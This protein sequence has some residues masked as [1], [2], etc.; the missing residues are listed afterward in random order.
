LSTAET[1][2]SNYVIPTYGTGGVRG[3]KG[4]VFARGEGAYLY[5]TEGRKYIDFNAGIAVNVIG[6]ADKEL[7]AAATDQL[8]KVAH[9]SNLY[10]TQPYLDLAKKLVDHSPGMGKVFFCNSG[11]EATEAAIKF[12]RVFHNAKGQ[13]ATR[14]RFISFKN[15][16]HGRSLGALSLTYKPAIRLPFSPMLIPKVDHLEFNDLDALKA[17]IGPDVVAVMMEPVQGEGGIRAA[18]REFVQL[19]RELCDEHGV[20]LI[21]DEVQIGL[22]RQGNGR[23]WAYEEYGV[24]P[25]ILTMAK[26]LA[27]GLPIGGILMKKEFFDAVP[28]SV[29]LGTHGSTFAGNP[30]VTRVANVVVDR[31][32]SPGFLEQVKENGTYLIKGLDT[33]YSRL[34]R[35]ILEVRRP[36]G[37]AALYAGIHLPQAC[38]GKIVSHCL[39]KGVIVV[40][41][42]DK[43][44][45]VR[46]CPPLIISKED[47]DRVLVVLQEAIEAEVT[48]VDSISAESPSMK[49]QVNMNLNSLASTSKQEYE[50]KL[51]DFGHTILPEGFSVGVSS[52]EFFPEELPRTQGQKPASMNISLIVPDA[53]TSKYAA[54]FTQNTFPGA[55]VKVGRALLKGQSPL[56]AVVINNKISNVHPKQSGVADAERVCKQVADS[57]KSDSQVFPSSTGVIGWRL[58]VDSMVDA[59]PR[60]VEQLQSKSILPVAKGIMT[61]DTFPKSRSCVIVDENNRVLG[62]VTG[63]AKGAGMIEPHMATMLVYILTDI[64]AEPAVLDRVLRQAVNSDGSFNRI[65]VDS[66][67]STSDT[68]LLVSSAKMPKLSQSI[69]ESALKEAVALVS[70]QLAQDVVRN[71]EGT[72]HVMRI[73]VTGAPSEELAHGTAKAVANSPLVKTAIAGNDPNVGRIIGAIGSF[74]GK[75]FPGWAAL[76]AEKC[77]ISVGEEVVFKNGEF[78]LDSE[79]E[80]KLTSYL[81]AN[82]IRALGYPDHYNTVDININLRGTSVQGFSSTVYGADL[83]HTYIDVNAGYRS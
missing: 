5:D 41:A 35:H 78:T 83:T 70:G 36:L 1:T 3:K 8:G 12:A 2:E 59:I 53:P 26:P 10:H 79:K 80:T 23:L 81:K 16:F 46:L 55:P 37:D 9:V 31:V 6:H 52:F 17:S 51:L 11:T 4:L 71:G 65:S 61:T 42:G 68:I 25:D 28:V 57:L 19:A 18:T 33:L 7:I 38:A 20:A 77:E 47:I 60:A 69:E 48:P 34:P 76:V 45:V 29:W 24:V 58:P 22:G 66:D 15:S 40:G 44:D 43:G 39:D 73:T 54:M 21:F 13:G 62:R 56:C 72:Q 82:E 75:E 49:Y 14:D 67:Q 63:I 74:I 32:L 50:S 64:D 27:G 30:L